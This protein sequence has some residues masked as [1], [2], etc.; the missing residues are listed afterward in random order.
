[1]T[2]TARRL[3]LLRR[4]AGELKSREATVERDELLNEIRDR[5]AEV[6]GAT[7]ESSAWRVRRPQAA[8]DP[9]SRPTITFR[10]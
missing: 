9:L 2:S 10:R 5:I 6:C 4:L 7:Y 3:E 1:L 8:A